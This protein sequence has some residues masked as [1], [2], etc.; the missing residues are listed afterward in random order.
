MA[1][2]TN[3]RQ[4]EIQ[5]EEEYFYKARA[6]DIT[7]TELDADGEPTG[8]RH[9]MLA[10]VACKGVGLAV[11]EPA[12]RDDMD[13]RHYPHMCVRWNGIDWDADQGAHTGDIYAR[14]R[15]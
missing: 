11:F 12:T 6:T 5:G 4:S 14:R 15:R 7:I 9:Y 2:R 8:R 10:N 3:W 1:Y 13:W